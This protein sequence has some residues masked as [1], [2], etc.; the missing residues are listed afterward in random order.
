[1]NC[2]A[3]D[4]HIV[5]VHIQKPKDDDTIAQD[6]LYG[7]SSVD[8]RSHLHGYNRASDSTEP[9]PDTNARGPQA[10]LRQ[11]AAA[12]EA[13]AEAEAAKRRAHMRTIESAE[14]RAVHA[15]DAR[16][17][18]LLSEIAANLEAVE[19]LALLH[20]VSAGC[21]RDVD[22]SWILSAAVRPPL[23]SGFAV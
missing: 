20:E 18:E 16:L 13:E 2:S 11:P 14:R 6:G 1:M 12:A 22:L 15:S 4:T 21:V 3:C 5:Q 7:L 8:A 9:E 19:G 17:H 23:P 10:R